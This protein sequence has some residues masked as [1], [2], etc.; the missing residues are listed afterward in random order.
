MEGTHRELSSRLADGLRRDHASG[1]AE[2]DEASGSEVTAIAH[3]ANSAFRF[4]GQHGADF[5][6]LDPCRLNRSR[7]F[8]SDFL[9]D[10]D[11]HVAVVIFEFFK[12]YTANDA[13]A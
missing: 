4:A 10:F 8:F 7:E 1:F 12:R 5:H 2:F 9:I 3:H 11:H 6:P 13:I